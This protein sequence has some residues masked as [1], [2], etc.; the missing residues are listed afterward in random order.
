LR[1]QKDYRNNQQGCDDRCLGNLRDSR[2][3]LRQM[4]PVG[5]TTWYQEL[6]RVTRVAEAEFATEDLAPVRFV[7]LIGEEGWDS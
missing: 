5:K 2:Q 7:P 1:K 6:V 4:I 3:Y